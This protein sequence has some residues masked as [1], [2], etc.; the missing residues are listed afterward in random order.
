MPNDWSVMTYPQYPPQ[1][2]MPA[3]PGYVEGEPPA[4]GGTAITAGVL[5]ILGGLWFIGQA[6]VSFS[7][8]M[9]DTESMTR[10][11]SPADQAEFEAVMPDWIGT[12]S[13]IGAVVQVILVV[14]L[15]VGAILLFMKKSVGR[16]MV[17]AGCVLA[18]LSSIGGFIFADMLMSDVMEQAGTDVDMS[19]VS[20]VMTAAV[21][22]FAFV[23]AIP[24]IATLI[25]ALVPPTGRWCRQGK[26]PVAQPAYGPPG[27]YPPPPSG[28][29]PQQW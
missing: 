20:G 11:M 25:L 17:V 9:M 27:A 19:G 21:G 3:H 15:L 6:V 16:W 13:I 28:Q 29:S 5:A 14:L 8:G 10:G 12:V 22:I 4:S 18:I 26:R 2:G 1:G 7:S 23:M 24:A